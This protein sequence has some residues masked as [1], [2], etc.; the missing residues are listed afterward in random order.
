MN[1][2]Q[3]QYK[4]PIGQTL[5]RANPFLNR[6]LIPSKE[7]DPLL[8][9]KLLLNVSTNESNILELKEYIIKNGITTSDMINEE[10]QSILHIVI[11]NDNLS[12]RQKLDIVKFLR[13]NFIST[14]KSQIATNFSQLEQTDFILL[15]KKSNIKSIFST[16]VKTDISDHYAILTDFI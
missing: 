7:I 9:S 16:I 1:R 3:Q 14:N 15:S 8:I 12:K 4:G 13:D 6:T 5:Q 10:G 2:A 11:A